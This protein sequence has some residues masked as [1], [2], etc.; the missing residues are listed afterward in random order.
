MNT[1]QSAICFPPPIPDDVRPRIDRA[2]TDPE[3][4]PCAK[5]ILLQ[6]VGYPATGSNRAV[7]IYMLRSSF[8]ISGI[9]QYSPRE[10]KAAVKE[11]VEERG[12][13]VGSSRGKQPGYFLL[14]SPEDR[15]AA[16]RPIRAQI[17]A[18]MKRWRT[19]D[20]DSA[21]GL[22]L[23]GQLSMLEANAILPEAS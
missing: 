6:L 20:A 11:L 2:L 5:A 9:K 12:V 7:S 14:V 1:V 8:A 10:I 23:A 18:E 4:S 16:I 22:E 19:L 3:I 13:P 21:I 15:R 17:I